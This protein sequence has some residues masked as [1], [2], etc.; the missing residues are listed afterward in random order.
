MK[1]IG[2]CIGV[3]GWH[4]DFNIVVREN[5]GVFDT[6]QAMADHF[7]TERMRCIRFDGD[8]SNARLMAIPV[9]RDRWGSIHGVRYDPQNHENENP[10]IVNFKRVFTLSLGCSLK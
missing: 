2:Y 9:H 7:N 6:P 8:D 5:E 4:T 10:E 3:K 1:I